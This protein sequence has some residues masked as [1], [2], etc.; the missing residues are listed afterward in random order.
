[1]VKK[2]MWTVALLAAASGAFATTCTL[3]VATDREATAEEIAAIEALTAD[4]TLQKTGDGLLRYT[5][6]FNFAGTLQLDAGTFAISNAANTDIAATLT[7]TGTFRQE[8]GSMTL[9]KDQDGFSGDFEIFGGTNSVDST[10]NSRIKRFGNELGKLVVNGGLLRM[11]ST[12]GP[13]KQYFAKKPVHLCGAGPDGTGVFKSDGFYNNLFN[14]L[15]L[16][17]DTMIG[18]EKKNGAFD[19]TYVSCS[20]ISSIPYAFD[21]QGHALTIT[22]L[23]FFVFNGGAD[24]GSPGPIIIRAGTHLSYYA[25]TSLGTAEDPPIEFIVPS[26]NCYIDAYRSDPQSRPFEIDLVGSSQYVRLSPIYADTNVVLNSTITFKSTNKGTLRLSADKDISNIVYRLNGK[27]SGP[28]NIDISTREQDSVYEFNYPFN[29]FTGALKQT[30]QLGQRILFAYPGSLPDYSKL[31]SSLG[32]VVVDGRNW[33]GPDVARLADQA[34]IGATAMSAANMIAVDTSKCDGQTATITLG[35][36]DVTDGMARI[37]HVGEGMLQINCNAAN[38]IPLGFAGGMLK[39]SGQKVVIDANAV[40][41]Q[42][43]EPY[44]SLPV[45]RVKSSK[46][47]IDGAADVTLLGSSTPGS[48]IKLGYA[49]TSTKGTVYAPAT[50]APAE[51]E[52]RNS[53]VHDDYTGTALKRP[54]LSIGDTA[55]GILTV[56]KGATIRAPIMIGDKAP[57]AIYQTSGSVTLSYYSWEGRGWLA[58]N[59]GSYGYY[60][61][62]DG[63]VKDG[64][65]GSAQA[66]SGQNTSA[67]FTQRDGTSTWYL[68]NISSGVGTYGVYNLLGGRASGTL[69]LGRADSGNRDQWAVLNIDGGE[70][71]GKPSLGGGSSNITA[72]VNLKSGRLVASQ[73][74]KE[75]ARLS[76]G[77]AWRRPEWNHA[78]LNFNGGTLCAAD[79][80][81]PI[82]Y[83][84]DLRGVDHVTVYE[85]GATIEIPTSRSVKMQ[86]PLE[87]PTGRGIASV[88]WTGAITTQRLVGPP[89]INILGDGFGATAIADFDTTTRAVTGI[90]IMSPGRDYTWAKAEFRYG[91]TFQTNDCT[92]TTGAPTSG[93]LV[94][95]GAGTLTLDCPNTFGGDITVEEGTL[96]LACAD[97]LPSGVGINYKGGVV[98][99]ASGITLPAVNLA[100][101]VG[102]TV[103][104]SSAVAF[105]AGSTVTID[106]LAAVDEAESPYVLA[107][108][109]AGYTGELTV[110]TETPA[111]WRIRVLPRS[112]RLLK[113]K[114]CCLLVK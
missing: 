68:F 69:G 87:A 63:T 40:I 45:T 6:P 26:G 4:D 16:D 113:P 9:T 107:T 36:A 79:N 22:N 62:A 2:E 75:T 78:Y 19:S 21:M 86:S 109:D 108:F 89:V 37:G 80:N 90:R 47:I 14:R 51:M 10:P 38:P 102:E 74:S 112:I 34:T 20:G 49:Y 39:L 12:P 95:T 57:G 33:T 32:L 1:M 91:T 71:T 94:K 103:A 100:L 5:A 18:A 35:D 110:L 29:D 111:N 66:C 82:V 72:I 60:D 17:G 41:P 114:G 61:F 43:S 93:G 96:H 83:T 28:G 106:N 70:L 88:P 55:P 15:V 30:K 11:W 8:A 27:I 85:G 58:Y 52:I 73:L 7:G 64:D 42:T 48:S 59:V 98:T 54:S 44:L 46:L 81:N 50:D 101:T 84:N 104:Y 92:L 13:N 99:A 67:V 53:T 76:D 65:A 105:P 23:A 97:A 56:G 31:E 77:V 3:D 24:I 25:E